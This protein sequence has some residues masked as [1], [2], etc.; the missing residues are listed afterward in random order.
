MTRRVRRVVRK[1]VLPLDAAV[2]ERVNASRPERDRPKDGRADEHE[3]DVRVSA[4]L[5]DQLR[6]PFLNLLERQSPRLVHEV[7]ETE[8]PRGEHDSISVRNAF[9]LATVG[10]W[11][12][13]GLLHR[14]S[15]HRVVLVPGRERRGTA[16]GQRTAHEIGEAVAVPLLERRPLRLPV[17]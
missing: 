16:V 2:F 7:D 9:C 12:A 6:V 11:R 15:D 1:W 13:G 14:V 8:V 10:G 3:A 5:R 17:V 4:E